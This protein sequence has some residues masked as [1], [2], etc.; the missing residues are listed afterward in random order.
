MRLVGDGCA[1]L[2]PKQDFLGEFEI[3]F[4]A[5]GARIVENGRFA[6]AGSFGEA[7]IAGNAGVVEELTE[8]RLEFA[9]Y[10]LGEIGAVVVHGED[11]AF[12]K[13]AGIERLTDAFDGIEELADAFEGKILGLHGDEDGIGGYEGVEGEQVERGRAIDDENAELVAN[14]L[15]CV[16]EAIFAEFRVDQ[17]DVGSDEVLGGWDDLEQLELGWQ[18][19]FGGLSIAHEELVGPG[20][21]GIL[22]KA[23]ARGGIGLRIAIDE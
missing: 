17:L 14:G 6:V 10:A 20:T 12:D 7:D 21:F 11:D 23:E 15:E 18:K 13:E 16:A 8:E 22:E 4:G 1:V 2:E 19:E 3:A 9:G 5:P